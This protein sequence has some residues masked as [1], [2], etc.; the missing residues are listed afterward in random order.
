MAKQ[1]PKV[2]AGI[3]THAD[4]HHVAVISETG[5]HFG[6]KEFL[7]ASFGYRPIVEFI[8]G[9]GPAPSIRAEGTGSYGAELARVLSR[10][11]FWVLEVMR[12]NR[13][14]RPL[15][16]KSDPL[17]AYQ[18]AEAALAGSRVSTPKA[19]DGAVESLRVLRAEQNSAMRARVAVMAQIKSILVSA[20]EPIRAKYRSLS[21]AA[22]MS[23]VEK[24]PTHR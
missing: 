10:E 5:R 20:P 1:H 17:D 18:A 4:T 8:K 6:D 23:A 14:E 2:I 3:D 15:R 7:A 24:S 22:T 13:Q 9:L 21:R 19:R 12:P 11:H 16:E